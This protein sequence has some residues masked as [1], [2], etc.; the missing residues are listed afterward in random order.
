MS[1]L[2]TKQNTEVAPLSEATRLIQ[3]I[4]RA[5]LNPAV[6]VDKME[7]LLAMQERVMAKQAEAAFSMALNLVQANLPTIERKAWNEQTKSHY[8]KLEAV[9]AALTPVYSSNGLSIS[10]GTEESP[11]EGC[12]RIVGDLSHIGGHTK[13][14]FLDVPLDDVGI[15]GKT[16]KTKVHAT[17]ASLSYGRRY[18]TLMMFNASTFDDND[19]NGP[20]NKPKEPEGYEA[21]YLNLKACA[22]DSLKALEESFKAGSLEFRKYMT[23]PDKDR[24][25][26]LK[27]TAR[28]EQ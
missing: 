10:W 28:G 2:A 11:V 9:N 3:A 15:L 7:R 5:T 18:L 25:A 1:E 4:E 16:N 24:F 12:I 21:W 14:Y 17:G 20:K 27:K 19:G 26:E 22:D 8:A 13:R 6:D 23:G